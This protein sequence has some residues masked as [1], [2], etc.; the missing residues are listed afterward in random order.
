MSSMGE[1]KFFLGLQVKQKL[2]GIFI[3]QDKYVA[4]IL[5]KFGLTDRKSASTPIDT[6]KPLLKDPDGED[7]DMHTYRSM[8]GSLMYLTSS[9]PDILF[10][11]CAYSDYAGASL[12]RKSTTEGCQFL[13]CRLISWQCKKQTIIATSSTEAEYVAAV[14]YV[15]RLQALVDKKKV[16]ITEATIQD[17]LRLNDVKSIDYFPNEEIFIELSRMGYEKRSTKLTFYKAFF[18]PQWKFLIHTILQCMSAKR[19]SWN[20]FS[21]SMASVIICLLTGD[22]SVA[23]VDVPTAADEPSIPLPTPTTQPPPPPQ[24]LP[25]TLQVK[26]TPP[27]SHVAQPPSPQQ[28]PQ[29]PQSSHDAEIS[30]DLLHTLLETCTTLTRRG[31]IIASMDADVDVTLKDVVDI[32]KEV[33][34]DAEIEASAD[35]DELEPA[36]HKEVVKVAARRRKGVV[37]RDHEETATPSIII[38]S[39]AKS[40]DKGKEIL[41]GVIDQ[42]QRK[43][44]EDNAMMRYQALK[45]KP[46]TEAQARKNMMIYLRNMVGFKIDYFKGMSYDDIHPNFEKKFNSNVAL[47]EKTREQ[48]E[49]EDNKALKRTS[50]SQ[51]KKSSKEAEVG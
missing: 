36:E 50:E 12:D 34:V 22:A 47:L 29:P 41:D 37:I 40:K 4:E 10:A 1:L 9:R 48:M 51:A 35:D 27:P 7:M 33:V 23:I 31:R 5:R 14:N 16:I 20:E 13:K 24:D 6:K 42:V 44:K 39:E 19:T 32:T 30:M 25:S 45:R 18:S 11:V 3:N 15:T 49:E 28:K 38:H 43:E 21:S 8:I 17:A 26:P 2:D 46:Q